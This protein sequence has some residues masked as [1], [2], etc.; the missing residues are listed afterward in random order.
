VWKRRIASQSCV[1]A[2]ASNGREAHRREPHPQP[3]KHGDIGTGDTSLPH[4]R[5]AQ[6]GSDGAKSTPT[7][8]G[9][10]FRSRLRQQLDAWGDTPLRRLQRF[11]EQEEWPEAVARVSKAMASVRE[12]RPHGRLASLTSSFEPPRPSV[13]PRF[14]P[15]QP[16]VTFQ[17]A[18][19][20]LV[21]ELGVAKVGFP[22]HAGEVGACDSCR[23]C[24]AQRAPRSR[25]V[26]GGCVVAVTQYIT[27]TFEEPAGVSGASGGALVAALLACGVDMDEAFRLNNY[28]VSVSAKRTVRTTGDQLRACCGAMMIVTGFASLAWCTD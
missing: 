10:T 18:G 14:H 1:P 8:S 2:D 25:E 17:G 21:Y 23:L 11:K 7:P 3:H 12:L 26:H 19:L 9:P 6:G 13:M 24:V 16:T 28:M 22:R 4:E 27:E 15:D 5:A 20:L